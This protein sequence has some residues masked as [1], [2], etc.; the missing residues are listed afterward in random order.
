[1]GLS[2]FAAIKIVQGY[3]DGY[4]FNSDSPNE[5]TASLTPNCI[6]IESEPPLGADLTFDPTPTAA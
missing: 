3:L 1:M 6:K 2:S 5:T 4:N